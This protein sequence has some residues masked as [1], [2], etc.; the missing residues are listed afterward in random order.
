M[1]PRQARVA[2][3]FT[4]ALLDMIGL[5][6]LVP[7]LPGIMR[8]F[9]TDEVTVSHLFGIFVSTYALMQFL[10]APL[11]GALSDRW[12][13]RPVLL[14][15]IAVAAADYLVMGFAPT[16]TILFIGRVIAGLT[17]ANMTV[18][19]A[20]IA[21]VTPPEKRAANFGLVGAAFGMGFILGPVIGGLLGEYG[22]QAPFVGSALLNA[23]NWLFGL[24]VLPE[25]LPTDRRKA[26]SWTAL[27][28]FKSLARVF[29][30]RSV[31]VYIVCFFLF[32]LAGHTHPSIWTLYTQTRFGWGSAQVGLS[33]AVVGVL[34]AL[35]Q[36]GLTRVVTPRIG[37]FRTVQWGAI[38]GALT[39]AGFA[40][41]TEGWMMLT[42]LVPACLTW[43]ASPALQA[44]VSRNT[45]ADRQGEMQGSMVSLQSMAAILNPLIVTSLFGLATA[46]GARF[47]IPGAPYFFASSV[48]VVALAIL[49]WYSRGLGSPRSRPSSHAGLGVAGAKAP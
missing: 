18:V 31:T 11:L 9:A 41:A 49:T 40:S 25:S 46:P 34:A 2:F 10:A 15:S 36:G 45:P 38:V 1:P 13:R 28:P 29:S 26:M 35:S 16:L 20:Y 37:E 33:L 43:V 6:L 17:G 24:F 48:M 7:S 19:M 4:T 47:N 32:S 14:I 39:F 27:N 21:D 12:G 23:V 44:L 3:I 22:P 30:V 8:R 5:G 42:I